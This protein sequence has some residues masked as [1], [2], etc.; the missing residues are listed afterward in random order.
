M[1]PGSRRGSPFQ[2][3]FTLALSWLLS[4][5]NQKASR[6]CS[7]LREALEWPLKLVFSPGSGG[8]SV[9]L[10]LFGC[11]VILFSCS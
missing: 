4:H 11:N 1:P 9:Y 7:G 5:R 8:E 2:P 10:A 6:L 3:F